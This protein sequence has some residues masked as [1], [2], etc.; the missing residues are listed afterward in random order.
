MMR[1]LF[2]GAALLAPAA[3]AWDSACSKFANKSLEPGQLQGQSAAAC[4]SPCR[5]RGRSIAKHDTSGTRHNRA[6]CRGPTV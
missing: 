1:V 2:I 5:R 3:F 4:V 6:F